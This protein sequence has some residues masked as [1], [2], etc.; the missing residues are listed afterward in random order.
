ME[1]YRTRIVIPPDRTVIVQLPPDLPD[2]PATLIIRV[3]PPAPR[4]PPAGAAFEPA[5]RPAPAAV[6]PGLDE[7]DIEWFDD[8]PVRDP[9]EDD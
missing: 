7:L 4:D 3:D 2:G 9:D 8:D 1:R 6:P 5:D